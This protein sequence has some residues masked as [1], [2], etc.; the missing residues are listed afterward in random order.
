M[1]TLRPGRAARVQISPKQLSPLW[2]GL[3]TP[4]LPGPRH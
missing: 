1:P 2:G 4:Y 3:L